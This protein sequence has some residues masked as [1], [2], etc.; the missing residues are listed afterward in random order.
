MLGRLPENAGED[1]APDGG[2]RGD[3]PVREEAEYQEAEQKGDDKRDAEGQGDLQQET[4]RGGEDRGLRALQILDGGGQADADQK[5]GGREDDH[6]EVHGKP[7]QRP[8]RLGHVEDGVQRHAQPAEDGRGY[9]EQT[10]RPDE[11]GSPAVGDD[12]QE[13]FLHRRVENRGSLRQEPLD[14]L[15]HAFVGEQVGPGEGEHE[16][17]QGHQAEQDLE[18]DPR[19]EEQ[20]PVADRISPAPR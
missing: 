1:G 15:G 2:A 5:R 8:V 11:P 17:R 10:D 4:R 18:R 19:G 7:Q 20:T 6:S 16:Q 14:L 3:A 13:A 9:P 12:L